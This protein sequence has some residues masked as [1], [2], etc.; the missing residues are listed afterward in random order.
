MHAA[1]FALCSCVIVPAISHLVSVDNDVLTVVI[2]GGRTYEVAL[3]HPRSLYATGHEPLG[4]N[5]KRR[6][7]RLGSVS[8]AIVQRNGSMAKA[9]VGVL[10]EGGVLELNENGGKWEMPVVDAFKTEQERRLKDWAGKA[11]TTCWTGQDAGMR[12]VK[13]GFACDKGF[14]NSIGGS[15]DAAVT[16]TENMMSL[17]NLVY[18][19]QLSVHLSIGTFLMP[20]EW[21]GGMNMDVRPCPTDISG[22]LDTFRK[23]AY[24]TLHPKY[25]GHGT[26]AQLTDCFRPVAGLTTVGLA[27]VNVVCKSSYSQLVTTQTG[28]SS[29][30][31][32]AHELGHNFGA[33]H[34]FEDGQ[35]TTGGIMDYGDGKFQGVYQ[36]HPY[37]KKEMCKAISSSMRVKNCWRAYDPDAAAGAGWDYGDWGACDI[38]CSFVWQGKGKQYRFPQCFNKDKVVI[39]DQYCKNAEKSKFPPFEQP[40]EVPQCPGDVRWEFLPWGTCKS[41]YNFT[42][43]AGRAKQDPTCVD[44]K[45]KTPGSGEDCPA[46]APAPAIRACTLPENRT[47]EDPSRWVPG[48][49]WLDGPKCSNEAAYQVQ[50]LNCVDTTTLLPSR[51]GKCPPIKPLAAFRPVDA[52]ACPAS[53]DPCCEDVSCHAY[54]TTGDCKYQSRHLDAIACVTNPNSLATLYKFLGGLYSRSDRCMFDDAPQSM[55]PIADGFPGFPAAW[56]RVD[57]ALSG[58]FHELMLFSEGS[59]LRFSLEAH[60]TFDGYP[61]ATSVEFPG[62]EDACPKC[63]TRVAAAIFDPQNEMLHLWCG[64]GEVYCVSNQAWRSRRLEDF[65]RPGT[66]ATKW[67]LRPSQDFGMASVRGA[68]QNDKGLLTLIGPDGGRF[69]MGSSISTQTPVPL[70]FFG[71]AS[72][73]K[74]CAKFAF[75][76]ECDSSGCKTCQQGFVRTIWGHCVTFRSQTY[77]DFKKGGTDEETLSRSGARSIAEFNSWTMS[78]DSALFVKGAAAAS[79]PG[80]K[81]APVKGN[82]EGPKELR[83]WQFS[84]WVKSSNGGTGPLLTA[85]QQGD[86]VL[87]I[88]WESCGPSVLYKTGGKVVWQ[89]QCD[90]TTFG[91]VKNRWVRVGM[92]FQ[93]DFRLR[94]NDHEIRAEPKK[95]LALDKLVFDDWTLGGSADLEVSLVQILDY[96]LWPPLVEGPQGQSWQF[97]AA[98]GVVLVV[99]LCCLFLTWRVKAPEGMEYMSQTFFTC[100][101]EAY[102]GG[103]SVVQICI[104]VGVMVGV[105]LIM[106]FGTLGNEVGLL[107][108]FAGLFNGEFVYIIWPLGIGFAIFVTGMVGLRMARTRDCCWINLHWVFLIFVLYKQ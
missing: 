52:P 62:L 83:R 17:T 79:K 34:S 63:A 100:A 57:A 88:V 46:P 107:D 21:G 93:A 72:D 102:V 73:M 12:E 58:P 19:S 97:I 10:W 77:L 30:M 31:I 39:P 90:E 56:T 22:R 18:E 40:C 96:D 74:K 38:A 43:G 104:G 1:W 65:A 54:K 105:L 87:E 50:E 78:T 103:L 16:F 80:L 42:C 11:F 5:V 37:R 108:L 61:K 85:K 8:V 45:K 24:S 26:W 51:P 48:D 23:Y 49:G 14:I 47:C 92:D 64:F 28:S 4:W 76:G 13:I 101:V 84:V 15:A 41:P 33:G 91:E 9:N 70:P 99:G 75:C 53:K 94:V 25:A 6:S 98:A 68:F 69:E 27:Y 86:D 67:T 71:K 95:H 3:G 36:F 60:K 59:V 44:K 82:G 2:E 89:L 106:A 32:F 35:G 55:Y 29:W 66:D 20:S 81:M 7:G